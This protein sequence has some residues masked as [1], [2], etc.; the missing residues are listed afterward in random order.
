MSITSDGQTASSLSGSLPS[1]Q[2]QSQDA[3]PPQLRLQFAAE[4]EGGVVSELPGEGWGSCLMVI[5][6]R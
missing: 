6:A 5:R 2:L 1:V 4:L 3:G